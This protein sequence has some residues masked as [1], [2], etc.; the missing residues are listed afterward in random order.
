MNHKES[1]EHQPE[2]NK[3]AQ[4]QRRRRHGFRL[5]TFFIGPIGFL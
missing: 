4:R 3:L 5:M 1:Q 2:E